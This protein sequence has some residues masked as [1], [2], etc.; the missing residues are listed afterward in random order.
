MEEP[1]HIKF[2]GGKKR[3]TTSHVNTKN[4]NGDKCI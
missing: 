4:Y 3:Q 1:V 2:L